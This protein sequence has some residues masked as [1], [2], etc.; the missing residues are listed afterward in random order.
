MLKECATAETFR[1]ATVDQL[2]PLV[3]VLAGL[4]WPCPV[5]QIPIIIERLGW[6]YVRD[7]VAV[8]TDTLL[9][10]NRT[11]GEI[12]YS[13]GYITR[14]GF[15][16]SDYVS[17]SD[18]LALKTVSDAFP[19]GICDVESI[20]GPQSHEDV[21]LDGIAWDLDSGGRIRLDNI[22]I[23]LHAWLLSQD[24]ADAERFEETHDISEFYDDED[25]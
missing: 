12:Y 6:V 7:L 5:S 23:G 24:L 10:I 20:L 2:R 11:M 16:V 3:D 15:P 21:D 18:P 17:K 13:D 4:E 22:G 14:L 25:E 8:E 1:R 9:P 19:M